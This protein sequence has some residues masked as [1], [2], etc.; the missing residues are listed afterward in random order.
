MHRKAFPL[1]RRTLSRW[2]RDPVC[3]DAGAGVGGVTSA[4]NGLA[5][6]ANA[7]PAITNLRLGPTK[8]VRAR[9]ILANAAPGRQKR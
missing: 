9:P 8:R 5:F 2:L 6:L 1:D 4:V 3:E 7:G